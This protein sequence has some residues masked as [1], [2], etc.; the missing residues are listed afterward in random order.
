[1]QYQKLTLHARAEHDEQDAGDER[2]D[3]DSGR[4]L[5]GF[6]LVHGSFDGAE[7][8]YFFLFVIAEIGVDKS[9]HSEHQQDDSEK[10]DEALHRP[11]AITTPA[12]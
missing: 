6:F 9:Y 8:R 10:D 2:S 12:I 5:R 1:L 4:D 11:E 3:R 7:F